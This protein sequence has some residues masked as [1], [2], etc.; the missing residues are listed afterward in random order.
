MLW[1]MHECMPYLFPIPV[2]PSCE[3]GLRYLYKTLHH[4]TLPC[5]AAPLSV[6]GK[7]YAEVERDAIKHGHS[8]PVM[9]AAFAQKVG[10]KMLVLNHFSAR[11]RGD[12][13]DASAAVMQRIELQAMR[14]GG[15]E[16]HQVRYSAG[17]S[18][19]VFV[20]VVVVGDFL[21]AV[22]VLVLSTCW[23]GICDMFCV[24]AV[25]SFEVC[26]GLSRSEAQRT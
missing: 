13:S 2:P 9:A 12:P 6:Q 11:Y 19:M 15:L 24:R 1:G 7:T 25:R 21:A 20:V 22:A 5:R 3:S 18:A 17:V 23:A 4:K 10:A 14:A 16:R 26:A 8:T